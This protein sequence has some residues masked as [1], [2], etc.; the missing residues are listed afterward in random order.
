[1]VP[2][3]VNLCVTTITTELVWLQQ[4]EQQRALGAAGAE[5]AG[6]KAA[7]AL[8][9]AGVAPGA[10]AGAAGAL[11][12]AKA[13][14]GAGAGAAGALGAAGAAPGAGAAGVFGAR[15]AG[16]ARQRWLWE[17][18]RILAP[19]VQLLLLAQLSRCCLLT[20]DA[21]RALF[22]PHSS[23]RGATRTL[24]LSGNLLLDASAIVSTVACLPEPANSMAASDGL[25]SLTSLNLS[26][27]E[28]LR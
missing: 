7:G 12:A 22:G 27:I 10:G 3:L 20:S 28:S 24:D 13:A 16:Q 4:Q 1:M 8:G 15:T 2:S 5:A 19:E 17:L 14:P 6:A 18:S 25:A 9:A 23:A 11:G 21:L 26:N